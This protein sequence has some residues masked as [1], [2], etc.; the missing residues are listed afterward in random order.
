MST[1]S[2]HEP[3]PM[4]DDQTCGTYPSVLTQ[5]QLEAVVKLERLDLYN[6]E[7]PFGAKAVW[8]H[9]EGIGIKNLPSERTIGRILEKQGLTCKTAKKDPGDFY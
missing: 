8:Q 7:K 5:V 9:L 4:Y 6:Q 1:T 3:D 2:M